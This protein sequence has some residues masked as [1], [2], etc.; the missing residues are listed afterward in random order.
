MDSAPESLDSDDSYDQVELQLKKQRTKEKTIATLARKYQGI[1]KAVDDDPML[2][3][4]EIFSIEP[5][6]GKI[7]PNTEITFCVT[8]R[9][10]GPYHYSCTAFCNTTCSEERLALNMTG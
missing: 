5:L 10:Q 2:F 3:Q 1:R 8:F 7:W 4:D 9:P 6:D